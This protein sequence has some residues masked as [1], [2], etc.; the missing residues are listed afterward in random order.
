[1]SILNPENYCILCKHRLLNQTA[2]Q[3]LSNFEPKYKH[4]IKELAN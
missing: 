4:L 1:M 3:P 2:K